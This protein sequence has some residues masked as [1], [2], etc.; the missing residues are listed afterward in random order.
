MKGRCRL[1]A[2]SLTDILTAQTVRHQQTFIHEVT[3]GPRHVTGTHVPAVRIVYMLNWTLA[4]YKLYLTCGLLKDPDQ[5]IAISL[6]SRP[7]AGLCDLYWLCVYVYGG[8]F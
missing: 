6:L 1:S 7:R 8:L 2:R 5:L 3:V 4:V